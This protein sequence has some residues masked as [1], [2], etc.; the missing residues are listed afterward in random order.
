VGRRQRT[1]ND[2]QNQKPFQQKRLLQIFEEKTLQK[3]VKFVKFVKL[4]QKR[5]KHQQQN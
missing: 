1:N 4:W 3:F 2:Q 5:K